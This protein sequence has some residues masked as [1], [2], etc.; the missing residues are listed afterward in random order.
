M[1]HLGGVASAWRGVNLWKWSLQKRGMYP[2]YRSGHVIVYLI[3]ALG[4]GGGGGGGPHVA[5]QILRYAMSH[6]LIV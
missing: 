5:C 6:V 1:S 3:G 2:Y 4:G